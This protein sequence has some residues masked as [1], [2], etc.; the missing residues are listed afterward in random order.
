[1]KGN[2]SA[3]AALAASA[4]TTTSSCLRTIERRS[5]MQSR[6]EGG[7]TNESPVANEVVLHAFV[8]QDRQRSRGGVAVSL[9]VVRHFLRWK[10]E[11]LGHSFDD[12]Q[13]SLM[14]EQH[15]DV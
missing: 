13:I 7:E 11:L 2:V 14:D 8:I 4:R 9:D 15:V 1:M 12:A 5:P 3:C 10:S 6:S